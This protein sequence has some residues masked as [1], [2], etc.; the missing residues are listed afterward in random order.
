[1]Y[2]A[3]KDWANWRWAEQ[4]ARLLNAAIIAPDCESLQM[5]GR[6]SG[7]SFSKVKASH[8]CQKTAMRA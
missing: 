2:A 7:P 5:F 6:A 4:L 8:M 1:M 3:S